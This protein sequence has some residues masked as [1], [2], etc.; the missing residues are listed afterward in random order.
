MTIAVPL[1]FDTHNSDRVSINMVGRGGSA[2]A[3]DPMD[4]MDNLC[5]ITCRRFKDFEKMKYML[6]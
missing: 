4:P 5:L 6:K 1:H 3:Q 2:V